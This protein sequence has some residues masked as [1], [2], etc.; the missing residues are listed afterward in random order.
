MKKQERVKYFLIKLFY[1][2]Q[3]SPKSCKWGKEEWHYVLRVGQIITYFEDSFFLSNIWS[4]WRFLLKH[5]PYGLRY[6]TFFQ[7][8]NTDYFDMYSKHGFN[9][10]FV[11]QWT[12]MPLVS[13]N[14]KCPRLEMVGSSSFPTMHSLP[15]MSVIFPQGKEWLAPAFK[16]CHSVH[17][18]L[19]SLNDGHICLS[20]FVFH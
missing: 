17:V 16:E 1:S 9:S 18:V 8:L 2:F 11:T 13:W 7:D 14:I 5:F 12:D 20:F 6:I 4:K 10:K 19:L 15:I 3:S